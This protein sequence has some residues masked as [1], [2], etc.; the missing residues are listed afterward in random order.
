[1][2]LIKNNPLVKI[3]FCLLLCLISLPASCRNRSFSK[4]EK[5]FVIVI[6]PHNSSEWYQ[7]N[8]GA[9]FNQQY[10]NYRVIYIADGTDTLVEQYVA[11][12]NLQDRI[13]LLQNPEQ[14]GFLACLCEAI[15]SCQKEEIVIDLDGCSRIDSDQALSYLNSIYADSDVWMTYGQFTHYPTRTQGFAS[16][17]PQETIDNNAFRRLKGCTPHIRTFYA[18]L[19]QEIEK[20]DFLDEGLFFPAAG[21]LAYLLPILEMTGS[22]A[23]H[24]PEVLNHFSYTFSPGPL[25]VEDPK[26][27]EMIPIIR[28]KFPYAPLTELPLVATS[29]PESIY[30]QIFDITHPTDSDYR[31]VQNYLLNGKRDNLYYLGNLQ[32]WMRNIKLIGDSPEERPFFGSVH[33][34][35][36][37]NDR[38]NCILIYASFNLNF[39]RGLKR[40]LKHII[41]SDYKGHVLYRLGGWPNEEDGDLALAHVPYAFK[42]A[43]M[44]EAQK[45]GF[46]RLLWLDASVLPAANL[47]DVFAMIE[48]K[49]YMLFENGKTVGVSMNEEAAAYFG[50][51]LEDTYKIP[52][53]CGGFIGLDLTRRDCRTLL[54]LWHR[55]AYDRDAFFSF[56]S[57]Q[58]ALSILLNQLNMKDYYPLSRIPH[59]EIGEK[60]QPDSI[61]FLDRLYVQR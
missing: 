56:R 31:F 37:P 14:R 53:C 22:H 17:I 10:Q 28:A 16:P 41:D 13:T 24:V 34:N 27:A 42:P 3:C 59:A 54:D 26:T 49:G 47:N 38:E 58:N 33:V 23:K 6:P 48:D 35:C 15:F 12:H 40:L 44:K 1:M 57:D 20:L 2:S 7:Q 55:A 60:I 4:I 43:F 39:P 19:F 30:R 46:K 61:F 45:L 25:Q 5:P 11:E 51:T 21:N 52:S 36:N 32:G 8:L 29:P 18:A 50:L 9:I